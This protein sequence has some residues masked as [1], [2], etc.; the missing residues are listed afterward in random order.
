MKYSS[1]ILFFLSNSDNKFHKE[2]LNYCHKQGLTFGNLYAL[3]AV[4]I[5]IKVNT[6]SAER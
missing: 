1:H 2:G 4:H 6:N 3:V 5:E